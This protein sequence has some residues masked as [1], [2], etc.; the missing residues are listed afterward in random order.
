MPN[1]LFGLIVSFALRQIAKFAEKTDWNK[2][3]TDI[4]PRIRDLV[5]GTMLDDAAVD[6][7]NNA[8]DC[9]ALAL[10]DAD[11]LKQIADAVLAG[12]WKGVFDALIALLEEVTHPSKDALIAAVDQLR[13][14]D[15]A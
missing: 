9:F 13:L 5:P 12:D 8:V 2:V 10:K 1:F 6:L 4:D 3:K 15:A 7:F 14:A 11:D